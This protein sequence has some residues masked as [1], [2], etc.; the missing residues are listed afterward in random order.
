MEGGGTV[1]GKWR[2]ERVGGESSESEGEDIK[3][4]K[5]N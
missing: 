1:R 4:E 3:D 2:V 5:K